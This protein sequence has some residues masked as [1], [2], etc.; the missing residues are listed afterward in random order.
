MKKT[1]T[2]RFD[3][4]LLAQITDNGEENTSDVFTEITKTHLK[5]C[6]IKMY[7]I[8]DIFTPNE[9]KGLANSLNGTIIDEYMHYSKDMFIAHN[10]DAERFE[11]AFSNMGADYK[12]VNE[13]IDGL[14]IIQCAT[15]LER[16]ADF[17][18]NQNG[19]GIELDKWAQW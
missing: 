18:A 6:K 14:T 5:E 19:T 9:W 2:F 16:V 10:E 7:D 17:W 15:I 13:K 1:I 3:E 11:G 12:E 4:D 8:R